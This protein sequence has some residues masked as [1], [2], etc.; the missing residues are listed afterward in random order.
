MILVSACLL[1]IA[2]RYDGQSRPLDDI[3]G[4][5]RRHG[6]V[7]PVCPE[8]LGGLPTPRP[9]ASLSEG[10]G[11]DVLQ[12][13]AR[14]IRCKDGTDITAAFLAGAEHC[15]EIVRILGVKQALL[16][17]GSPSCGLGRPSGVTAAALL[18]K[19]LDVRE[20]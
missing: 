17:S 7:I 15:L 20:I 8:Q 10:D 6:P 12:G 13:R 19:G 18:L 5:V 9:P 16:K 14:V 1:G 3:E 11:F 4:L 2:C